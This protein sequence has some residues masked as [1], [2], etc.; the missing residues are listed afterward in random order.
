M[1]YDNAGNVL[2]ETSGS[3]TTASYDHHAITSYGYDA[4]NRLNQVIRAYGSTAASTATM[5]YD[6]AGNLLSQTDGISV[7]ASYDHHTTARYGYDV[8][9]RQNQGIEGEGT[10]EATTAR[11]VNCM[12]GRP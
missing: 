8:M 1:I 4:V 6:L 12:G 10:A 11:R 7:T 2:S 5:I 9:N 3:S